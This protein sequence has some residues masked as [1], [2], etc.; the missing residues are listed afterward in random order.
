MTGQNQAANPPTA[1]SL[2]NR[3]R[4]MEKVLPRPT[5]PGTGIKRVMHPEKGLDWCLAL[6]PMGMP[7]SFFTGPTIEDVVSQGE[8]AVA[9]W[10]GHPIPL[11]DSPDTGVTAGELEERLRAIEVLQRHPTIAGSEL[12]RVMRE[13]SGFYWS[14]AVG[15]MDLPK[16]FFR[17]ETINHVVLQAER[18]VAE[19]ADGRLETEMDKLAA[20]LAP[21]TVKK[22]RKTAARAAG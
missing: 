3:L 22:P 12:K 4:A 9:E 19:S 2:D 10:L 16:A 11:L 8:A 17:G 14:L 6:G 13:H 15:P 1:A 5:I 18:A 21:A 20:V 7:K